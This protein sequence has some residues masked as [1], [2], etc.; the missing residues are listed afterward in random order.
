M[1]TSFFRE[2]I[3][4]QSARSMQAT[5]GESIEK[6]LRKHLEGLMTPDELRQTHFAV[7][8]RGAA[9]GTGSVG[10][11]VINPA[12]SAE[13]LALIPREFV[14]SITDMNTELRA[15]GN[16]GQLTP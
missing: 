12:L 5:I 11:E 8:M 15:A 13:R 16:V 2:G 9:P 7:D 4:D 1:R 3:P 6:R 10:L 14:A